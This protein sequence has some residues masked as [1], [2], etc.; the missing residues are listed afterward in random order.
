MHSR[1]TGRNA[2]Q[3]KT[4]VQGL[5]IITVKRPQ[6]LPLKPTVMQDQQ[7]N[8]CHLFHRI[9]SRASLRFCR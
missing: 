2:E 7:A 4:T 8:V 3:S 9:G 6:L 1:V 5:K